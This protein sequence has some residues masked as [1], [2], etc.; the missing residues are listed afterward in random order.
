MNLRTRK[1]IKKTKRKKIVESQIVPLKWVNLQM[2]EELA[3]IKTLVTMKTWVSNKV[4]VAITMMMTAQL[5]SRILASKKSAS[6]TTQ[7][8]SAQQRFQGKIIWTQGAKW[9]NICSIRT[10]TMIT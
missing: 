4:P 10:M 2:L 7:T 5:K 6:T 8:S 1:K 9:V 3:Q